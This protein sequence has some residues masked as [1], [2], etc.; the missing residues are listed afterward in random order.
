MTQG[1]KRPDKFAKGQRLTAAS[2]NGLTEAIES[3]MRRMMG[4]GVIRPE[5]ISGKL[6][7]D[8]A[9]AT[10]FGTS[11]STATMSVWGKDASGNMV[12]TG[13]NETVVNR[14]E[15]IGLTSGAIV[16]AEWIDGE[17]RVYAADCG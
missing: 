10:S 12:D 15:R 2:L 4:S 7:G 17:W 16:H 1:D 6:D 11:P 5:N 9:Q 8:L 3:I 13:R 14:F